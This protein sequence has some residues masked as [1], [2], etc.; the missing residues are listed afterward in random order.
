MQREPYS[1]E[2]KVVNEEITKNRFLSVNT[3]IEQDT[4]GT[5]IKSSPYV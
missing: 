2:Q 5:L 3:P 4:T 1:H